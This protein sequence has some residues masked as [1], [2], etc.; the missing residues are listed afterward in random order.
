M[1]FRDALYTAEQLDAYL[2]RI[3]FPD[4]PRPSPDNITSTYG[5]TYL[6]RLQKYHQQACPFE[7]LNLHYA[8]HI[9]KSLDAQ[10]LYEK[11]VLKRWGGTCT[12]NNTFFGN[13]LRSFG[14]K[15]R[16]VGARVSDAIQGWGG[17]GYAAWNHCINI[18]TFDG[19]KYLV[20]IAMG[21]TAPSQ[22]VPLKDN[23]IQDGIGASKSRLRWDTIPQYTDSDCK[24][25]IYEQD[26]NGKSDFIPTYCF[27]ELEFLLQDYEIMKAGTTFNRRSFFTYRVVCVRT[28]LEEGTEDV[29][30]CVILMDG[31][32]KRRIRSETEVL[33]TFKNEEERVQALK[34]WF[35]IELTQK[36]RMGIKG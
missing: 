28:I 25:W 5:L 17:E 9:T 6:R 13:V 2:H 1:S 8:K 18:L 24:L 22:P 12:E 7:N 19:E 15:A 14:F 11:I 33:A 35:G 3:G 29:V 34:E 10:D 30:G 23:V 32:L 36:D 20:D 31:Q 26:S 27:S 4:I 16:P 21:A